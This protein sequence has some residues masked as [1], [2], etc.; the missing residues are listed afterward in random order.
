ME[1]DRIKEINKL[2]TE[3]YRVERSPSLVLNNLYSIVTIVTICI[4]VIFYNVY[5]APAQKA[6]EQ[7]ELK[8][9]QHQEYLDM[10]AKQIALSHKLNNQSKKEEKDAK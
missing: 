7:R 8:A 9:K 6:K 10:R 1:S 4:S 3:G 2:Q 5:I